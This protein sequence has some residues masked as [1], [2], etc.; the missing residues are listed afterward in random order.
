MLYEG[1][2]KAIKAYDQLIPNEAIP[3]SQRKKLKIKLNKN[4]I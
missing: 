3:G 2:L 4:R 1:N